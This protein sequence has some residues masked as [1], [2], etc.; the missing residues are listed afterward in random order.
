MKKQLPPAVGEI[1]E[2]V[3]PFHRATF[4][5]WD[6]DESGE[7][8]VEGIPTWTPGCRHAE[9]GEGDIQN[10]ADAFGRVVLTVVSLHK[11]GKY[12]TRVFFTRTWVNPDGKA[13]GKTTCRITTVPTFRLLTQGYRHEFVLAGCKCD[14]CK[15]PFQDHRRAS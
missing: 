10:V 6:G 2:S 7:G 11:P 1:F 15:W 4:G 8:Y 13:F 5:K 9:R 12:P 3:Y 14:G